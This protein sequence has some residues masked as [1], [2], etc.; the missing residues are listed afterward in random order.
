MLT[1][2]EET[3][4][5][6]IGAIRTKI[7][8]MANLA[9][10]A[11]EDCVKALLN[12]DR[13][14]AYS[15]ILRDRYIDKL[16]KEIDHLCLEFL[17]RQQPAGAPLRF[18]YGSIRVN[19]ELERVGDYAESIAHQ[20][21]KLSRIDV[22]IPKHR[23]V[24]LADLSVPTLKDAVTAFLGQDEELARRTLATEE[25][26]DSVKS[27]LNHDLVALFRRHEMPF[28]ALNPLMMIARRFERVSDQAANICLEAV[29]LCTGETA[30][31]PGTDAFRML[32]VDR[33]NSTLSQMAEAIASSLGLD[34]FIFNSAGVDPK[35]V[36]PAMLEFM[37]SKD[38]DLSRSRPKTVDQVEDLDHYQVIVALDPQ[39]RKAFSR[40]PRKAIFLD[41]IL[42]DS[43]H[44]EG[45]N[46][47]S[48]PDYEEAWQFLDSH[49]RDFTEAVL[50]TEAQS[51]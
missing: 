7:Q 12:N 39:A 41:W 34:Q 29:Y 37:K 47:D 14:L 16:E 19:L 45:A 6:D 38:L 22:D 27:N 20:F 30:K 10:G 43:S 24:Q 51:T 42:K 3:L 35:P 17:V 21:L 40:R 50:R 48:S 25:T 15:V 11:L 2:F 28:D 4:E 46:A 36:P 13:Q 8:A 26:V 32:F 23:F 49:I 44:P 5:R 18:A 31:H 33:E 1:H 9:V